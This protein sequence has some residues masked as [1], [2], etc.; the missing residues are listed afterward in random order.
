MHSG[1][2]GAAL[3]QRVGG[4]PWA[5][6][7]DTAMGLASGARWGCSQQR[8]GRRRQDGR[9]RGRGRDNGRGWRVAGRAWAWTRGP[10]I[11]Q[12]SDC[13]PGVRRGIIWKLT[14]Q[15]SCGRRRARAGGRRQ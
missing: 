4:G 7:F 6:G 9:G 2:R 3:S 10:G 11:N 5:R 8:A 14:W 12:A 15:G 1:W 13:F